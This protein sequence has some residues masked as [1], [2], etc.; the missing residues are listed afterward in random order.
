MA[1]GE[2]KEGFVWY[3]RD[4]WVA[5]RSV[6]CPGQVSSRTFG[7]RCDRGEEESQEESRQEDRQ[8]EGEEKAL[9]EG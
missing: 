3:R 7:W 6:E 4:R 5:F 9:L 8:E 2:V 1:G